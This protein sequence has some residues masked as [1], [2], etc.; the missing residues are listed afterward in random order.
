MSHN[1]KVFG[2]LLIVFITAVFPFFTGGFNLANVITILATG[3]LAVEHT[4]NG[5]TA[6]AVL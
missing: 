5:N 4:L 1:L 2:S 3:F 6:P